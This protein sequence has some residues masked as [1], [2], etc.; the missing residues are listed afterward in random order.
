MKFVGLRARNFMSFQE[1]DFLFPENGLYFV[2]GEVIGS[3]MSASNG[4]GKSVMFEALCWGLFGQT[5]R[6]ASKNEVISWNNNKDCSVEII[7]EGDDGQ[8]YLVQRYRNDTEHQNELLFFKAGLDITAGSAKDTQELIDAVVGLS[9]R[10]FSTA[11]VF[12]EKAQ[13]F[14]EAT[15][16][17]KKQIFDEILL[18]QQFQDAQ[19]KVKKDRKA[20][21]EEVRKNEV[22]KEVADGGIKNIEISI[23]AVV[24]RINEIG[25]KK[26]DMDK[27]IDALKEEINKGLTTYTE[28]VALWENSKT[29]YDE[30]T[31]QASE[32]QKILIETNQNRSNELHEIEKK[33]VMAK[34]NMSIF[35][36]RSAEIDRTVKN[37]RGF[38]PGSKC[39]TCGQD[40]TENSIDDVLKHYEDELAVMNK[41]AFALRGELNQYSD[42][43][44]KAQVLWNEKYNDVLTVKNEVDGQI[45]KQTE[46]IQ[47]N[48][49]NSQL[50][51]AKIRTCETKI[52]LIESGIAN[53]EGMLLDDK[54]R[55]EG[56]L[57]KA[58]EYAQ[59]C[60]AEDV[61]LKEKDGYLKFW[62]EGFGN[63]GI[64][65]LLLDE[66]IPQLNTRVNFYATSLLDDVIGISFDTESTLKS[67]ESRD[68][69]DVKISMENSKIDYSLCSAGEKRRI[70][71]AILLALQSL[72]F[73]RNAKNCNLL[74]FD[75]VFDSLDRT[76][77]ERVV[78]LLN[79]EAKQKTIYV[80]SHMQEFRDFFENEIIVCKENG[81]SS[82]IEER[83]K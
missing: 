67:G 56:E 15:D 58:K 20:L 55:F 60:L 82:I 34:T 16:A 3:A 11:V 59:K 6:G 43:H 74:V 1:L 21:E 7:L 33:S 53:Q 31:G 80:I 65:S 83:Q 61:L 72:V 4:A 35:D 49:R 19:A 10:V 63:K 25:I 2:G 14:V 24:R 52:K 78:N 47:E 17:E 40:I 81:I 75:E 42:E 30:L 5:I 22:A 23:E 38:I 8:M 50:I 73:E 32:L 45:K 41:E 48:Q 46:T 51:E 66:I 70:D 13:R 37:I 79:E 64:K 36:R 76:G 54:K 77:V 26:K 71:I 18:L 29:G 27:E 12:G 68:K 69:F 44:Q 57:V 9:W 28:A 62:E 39:P